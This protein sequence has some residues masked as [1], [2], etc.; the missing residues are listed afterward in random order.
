MLVSAASGPVPT[1]AAPLAVSRP[2]RTRRLV[3]LIAAI[4]ALALVA[5][6]LGI[7]WLGRRTFPSSGNLPIPGLQATVQV[8]MD[9]LGVPRI[10][11]EN[12][13]DLFQAQGYFDAA[14]RFF[15]MDYRRHIA[16]GRLAELVGDNGVSIG[17]D[18]LVRT[19]GWNRVAAAEW[20]MLDNNT[21]AYL[22]AYADG[23]NAYLAQRAPEQ[24]SVEY[25]QLR[26][27]FGAQTIEPWSPID[28]L[29]LLKAL[30][31]EMRSNIED[32]LDRV[33]A[34]TTLGEVAMADRLFPS[35]VASGNAPILATTE[36]HNE[37][38]A[39]TS[40]PDGLDNT[41]I[42]AEPL[43]S[44]VIQYLQSAL[45]VIPESFGAAASLGSN[46]FVVSGQYTA[47]GGPL[48]GNDLHL[49]LT[50]PSAFAQVGLHCVNVSASCP[51]D[52]AGFSYAG[53]PA[54][55]VGRND[56]LAWGIASLR[57]DTADLYFEALWD[58]ESMLDSTWVPVAQQTEVIT[59]AGGTEVP[60]TIRSINGRPIISDVIDL[61][62]IEDTNP[63]TWVRPGSFGVSLRWAALEPG[64]TAAGIFAMNLAETAEQV[65][66]AAALLEAPAQAV[67]F[68]TTS[69][70]IGFQAAG[71]VPIRSAAAHTPGSDI[72]QD[73]TWPMDGRFADNDWVGWIAPS[74][75]PRAL[76]PASG[77]IVAA[78]QPPTA[79]YVEPSLGSG[80]DYGFRAARISEIIETYI[81]ENW[82]ITVNTINTIQNDDYSAVAQELVPL[83]LDIDLGTEWGAVGQDLLRDWDYRM[84]ADSPAAAYFSATWQQVLEQTFW[85]ELPQ[86]VWPDGSSRWLVVIKQLLVS[87]N[88]PFWD[89]RSTPHVV[90]T[91]DEILQNAMLAARNQLTTRISGNSEYWRWGA[92][93]R[94]ELTNPVLG[95]ADRPR[96]MRHFANPT[97]V[98]PNGDT[99][100]VNS[101]TELIGLDHTTI[102]TG[103][104]F[105]MI[106]DLGALADSQW[107]NLPGNSGHLG[108]RHYSDQLDAWLTGQSYPFVFRTGSGTV[109]ATPST[110]ATLL[111][112]G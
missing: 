10:F 34:Y 64:R 105:R 70:D 107:V 5:G 89:D 78:N 17:S 86:G 83:L 93:H 9:E 1:V 97:P 104:V 100:T 87:P 39:T 99:L 75:M 29:A 21:R 28:S 80:F 103:P 61:N 18:G 67:V 33:L 40:A 62:A 51:F 26:R 16:N 76:N 23:I 24:V 3:A 58:N 36:I 65:Q 111:P 41:T 74:D 108:S 112:G 14:N 72:P 98:S 88:D 38:L 27:E 13:P 12:S 8:T 90:E 2:R 6:V 77:Y 66:Q 85:D 47:S 11:A 30:A 106:V 44:D 49:Q 20:E 7:F 22:Q 46:A 63:F 71:R 37:Q 82:P 43:K 96:W 53:F 42:L 92:L 69:G 4:V 73:G 54:I 110:F 94:L 31:W 48:L 19:M 81:A 50:V 95:T 55:W 32:E 56:N 45:S 59:V 15:Q 35:Y 25:I 102:I 60:L 57:A 91:R 101:T 52:V 84:E 109:G 68:A 79:L